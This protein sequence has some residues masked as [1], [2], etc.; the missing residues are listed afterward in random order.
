MNMD[1]T[2]H[3]EGLEL[4]LLERLPEDRV[5][6]MDSHLAH[7][8]VCR[9]TLVREFNSLATS[10]LAQLGASLSDEMRKEPRFKTDEVAS[11]QILSPFATNR[12]PGQLADVSRSGMKLQTPVQMECGALIKITLKS[13]IAFGDVR[14]RVQVGAAFHYGVQLSQM[15][16]LGRHQ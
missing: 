14:Y 9:Q 5:V 16:Q 11:F 12:Y 13:I 8:E 15:V 7:C 4:Y 2:L 3:P 10:D 6:T 1:A